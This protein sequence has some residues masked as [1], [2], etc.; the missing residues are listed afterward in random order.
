MHAPISRA[1]TLDQ[2]LGD[3]LARLREAQ[4]YRVRRAVD[5]AHGVDIIVDGRRCLNFCSNDY[6][7]LASDPRVSDAARHAL[8]DSGT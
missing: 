3:Q 2:R 6:L 7:G 1:P 8:T 4:L 5:G